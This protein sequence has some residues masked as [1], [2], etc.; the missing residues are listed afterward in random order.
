MCQLTSCSS[1]VLNVPLSIP[2]I[3]IGAIGKRGDI[4]PEGGI[5]AGSTMEGSWSPV[6]GSHLFQCIRVQNKRSAKKHCNPTR[7]FPAP[8]KRPA[9]PRD[10]F[11][12]LEKALHCCEMVSRMEK[13][14]YA[15]ARWFRARR[16]GTALLRDVSCIWS[17]L[18]R[19]SQNGFI[20]SFE[21]TMVMDSCHP[22]HG[23]RYLLTTCT[24]GLPA[25]GRLNPAMLSRIGYGTGYQE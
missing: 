3:I 18:K 8:G 13:R 12:H 15:S 4:P 1:F 11:P 5:E 23:E 21:M 22:N 25:A 6:D 10:G 14:H 9:L 24:F 20:T 2:V 19:I 16:K 7:R 17:L